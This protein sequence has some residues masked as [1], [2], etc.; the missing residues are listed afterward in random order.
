MHVRYT[1]DVWKTRNARAY[2]M[3]KRARLVSTSQWRSCWIGRAR[4]HARFRG[5]QP[6]HAHVPTNEH[7]RAGAPSAPHLARRSAAT[8]HALGASASGEVVFGGRRIVPVQNQRR[9]AGRRQQWH[10]APRSFVAF[11]PCRPRPARQMPY[12]Q[13]VVV[14]LTARVQSECGV[15]WRVLFLFPNSKHLWTYHGGRG[16]TRARP[17]ISAASLQQILSSDSVYVHTYILLYPQ[18][19]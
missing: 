10:D 6:Q 18:E 3:Q 4:V 8:A 19:R 2:P 15:R 12:R 13:L 11:S 1:A 5:H 7:R 17:C 9:E 16:D 14:N